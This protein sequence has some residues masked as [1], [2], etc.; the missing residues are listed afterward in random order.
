M[1]RCFLI[2]L[3]LT[4]S[5]LALAQATTDVILSWQP[6]TFAAGYKVHVGDAPGTYNPPLDVGD[7]VLV[8]FDQGTLPRDCTQLYAAVTAYNIT[9]ESG[10]SDEVAFYSRPLVNPGPGQVGPT[11][12]P[13]VWQIS[14]TSFAPGITLKINGADVE[15]TRDSCTAITFL[16]AQVPGASEWTSMELCN[17]TVCSS[18]LPTPEAPASAPVAN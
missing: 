2:L 18:A 7:N 13:Q 5:S 4:W 17:G 8:A 1:R 6:S 11:A 16:V 10:F 12:N 15:I 14:G 3:L 9:G